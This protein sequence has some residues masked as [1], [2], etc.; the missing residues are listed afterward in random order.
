MS[1]NKHTFNPTYI[2]VVCG[3]KCETS[4]LD[5]ELLKRYKSNGNR[6]EHTIFLIRTDFRAMMVWINIYVVTEIQI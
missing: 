2:R 4:G 5:R 6:T 1:S 3:L